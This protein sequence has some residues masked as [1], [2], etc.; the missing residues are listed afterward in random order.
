MIVK[1]LLD[2]ELGKRYDIFKQSNGLYGY[3]YYE[4][5]K[6]I[7]W[8]LYGEEND[9]TKESIEYDFDIKIA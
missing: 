8:K 5:F 3:R 4:F 7:G 1:T 9:F 2:N 6:S